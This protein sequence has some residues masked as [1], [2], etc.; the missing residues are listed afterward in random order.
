[1]TGVST[2]EQIKE[3]LLPLQFALKTEVGLAEQC[4]QTATVMK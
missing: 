2:T 4:C 1:M 3:L